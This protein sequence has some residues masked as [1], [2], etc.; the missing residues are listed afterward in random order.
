M[1]IEELI[2]TLKTEFKA[3]DE[4]YSISG[5]ISLKQL[6]AEGYLL[7][8]IRINRRS[9]GFADYP[10]FEF[11]LP[12]PTETNQFKNGCSIH[13]FSGDEKP[14]SGVLLYLEGNRGEIRLHA[15]DFPDWIDDKNIGVQLISDQR[16]NEIQLETLKIIQQSK[17]SLNL[18]NRLHQPFSGNKQSIDKN[19]EFQ[20]QSLNDSQQQAVKA[21]LDT[22]E[23]EVVHGPP[24]TGK[25]TTLVELIYQLNKQ[26]KKILVSAPSNTAVDNIGLRLAERN[27]DFLRVGNNVKVR[28]ELL[29]FTIEGKIEENNLKQTIKKMRIQSEQLRKM[30]H[31]YKRNFGRDEREQRKLLINEVKSIRKEIKSLQ[32]HFE[33]S[34]YEKTNVILGTPIGLYDCNFNE[35]SYDVLI[36]DEAGQCLESLTWTIIPFAKK[37]ILAGDPYQLPPTVISEE[38]KS[39]GFAVSLLEVLISNK[40]PVHLL[41]TQY[42]MESVIAEFSNRY[43]YEGKLKSDK[44]VS[45]DENH[46]FFYDTVG[47]DYTEQ[48]DENSASLYNIEELRFIQRLVDSEGVNAQSTVFIT[49]YNGQ[50]Q[51]AKDFFKDIPFQRFSTIDSF[52]GQEADVIILS[53]VRSNPNQKIGFLNDYRR[54]NVAMTR[55]RKE[56]YIIGDSGTVG[57]DEFYSKMLDYFEEVNAYHSVF[58]IA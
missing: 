27:I 20:N 39:K 8:P 10:E 42:R 22:E 55:A 3:Q 40:F 9:Y 15:S 36:M 44:P 53:L 43:F 24:G 32:R 7:Q 21:C 29:L 47:A 46:L 37:L 1:T 35:E 11:H 19:I 14:I 30:A 13:L 31:Q 41:D 34:C 33:E 49:P 23:V 16:T 2:S 45:A 58:E 12:F 38:A 25:T 6:R 18:F 17:K 28:E 26:G 5:G 51:Q 56:L 54:M 52:Q 50:L 48:E 57:V 4:R